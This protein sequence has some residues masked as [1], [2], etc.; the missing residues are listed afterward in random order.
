ML[1]SARMFSIRLA[2]LMCAAATPL[3][4][5][6]DCSGEYCQQ[7]YIEQLY[8]ESGLWSDNVWVQTSGVETN[9]SCTPNSS[10]FLRLSAT[11]SQ[12]KEILAVLLSAQ[13]MDR[14]V[15]IRIAT[16]STDCLIGYVTLDRQ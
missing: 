14:R 16:G 13:A 2:V 11:M 5:F 4:T 6:A 9:L 3:A 1:S 10:V 15:G 12:H 8:V 7:V